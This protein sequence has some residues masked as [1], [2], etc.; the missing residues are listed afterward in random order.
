MKEFILHAR[1]GNDE[2]EKEQAHI[3]LKPQGFRNFM[4]SKEIRDPG[5]VDRLFKA[6]DCDRN[7]EV[8]S[9]LTV[10]ISTF[11]VYISLIYDQIS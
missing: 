9:P 11:L 1:M 3:K 4:R 7:G 6:V 2:G 10:P 5:L 8:C